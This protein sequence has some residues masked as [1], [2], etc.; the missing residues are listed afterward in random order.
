MFHFMTSWPTCGAL[1]AHAPWI[2]QMA[3]K[4]ATFITL[5]CHG[6]VT[7]GT[8]G[9]YSWV[10][11]VSH[12]CRSEVWGHYVPIGHRFKLGVTLYLRIT[13]T[14]RLLSGTS[15]LW[16]SLINVRYRKVI[17]FLT[18]RTHCSPKLASQ[19]WR[20]MTGMT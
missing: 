1:A 3:P 7:I 2:F 9:C 8:R 15:P 12:G 14:W 5:C 18:V 16:D 13:R 10:S 20:N 11:V 19:L 6:L 17:S 4:E